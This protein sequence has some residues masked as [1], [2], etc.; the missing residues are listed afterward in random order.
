MIDIN[1]YLH[2]LTLVIALVRRLDQETV[3]GLHAYL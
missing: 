1:D 2:L 3:D